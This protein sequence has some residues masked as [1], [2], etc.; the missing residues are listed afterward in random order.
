MNH[1][2]HD[3]WYSESH[4][5][6]KTAVTPDMRHAR[7]FY[8]MA[9]GKLILIQK[10]FVLPVIKCDLVKLQNIYFSAKRTDRTMIYF[11]INMIT[12]EGMMRK[13]SHTTAPEWINSVHFFL[14]TLT[15]KENHHN[16]NC[17]LLAC[18]YH[19]HH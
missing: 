11:R 12:F 3:C 17:L 2:V 18:H 8:W 15:D 5:F 1:N 7:K 14:S 6:D 4:S 19:H 10:P 9:A 16:H 13:F